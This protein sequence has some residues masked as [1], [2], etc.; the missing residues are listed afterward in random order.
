M[1][2]KRS[3]RVI[4]R[5]QETEDTATFVLEAADGRP[6]DYLPGQYLSLLFDTPGGEKRRAYSFSSCPGVDALP[7]I[8]VK[9]VPNGE[10]SNYLLHHTKPGD[11]LTATEARGRFLLPRKMPE[12]IFY[13]AAGSRTRISNTADQAAQYPHPCDQGRSRTQ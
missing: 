2:N 5:I 10:F 3:L 1:E 11:L 9:R 6:F 13:V 8:T 4:A 12:T 7:A